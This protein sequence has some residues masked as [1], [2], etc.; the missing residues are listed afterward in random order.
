MSSGG[1]HGEMV[2]EVC[3]T[4]TFTLDG[5]FYYCDGCGER[6]KGHRETEIEYQDAPLVN[7]KRSQKKADRPKG[8][9]KGPRERPRKLR[10]DP[11]LCERALA[12]DG[13]FPAYMDTVGTRICTSTKIVAKVASVLT[14]EPFRLPKQCVHFS[15]LILFAYFRE[16]SV[17]FCEGETAADA[18]K[19]AFCPLVR[20]TKAEIHKLRK[21][22]EAQAKE[23]RTQRRRERIE[24]ST[25]WEQLT[26]TF[27]A[28]SGDDDSDE[29]NA[30]EGAAERWKTEPISLFQ[31][32]TTA[33]STKAVNMAAMLYLGID[34]LLCIVFLA[35]QMV[36]AHWV[37]LS[38]IFRWYRE[39][40][41]SVSH[42]QLCALNFS[43]CWEL[44]NGRS[45]AEFC[46]SRLSRRFFGRC[47]FTTPYYAIQSSSESFRVLS[48]L[49]QFVGI[50]KS[51][52]TAPFKH[53]LFRLVYNL[54]L[55]CA[56]E[57][58]LS[59]LLD[60]L[61]SPLFTDYG[62][63]RLGAAI[64]MIDKNELLQL[65]LSVPIGSQGPKGG[66]RSVGF[67][68]F[69]RYA[70][71]QKQHERGT[72]AENIEIL[73]DRRRTV[74]WQWLPMPSE[75]NAAALV[76]FAMKLFFGLDGEDDQQQPR[77]GTD[78]ATQCADGDSP[79]PVFSF[80]HWLLQLQLRMHC[81]QGTTVQKV[82]DKTFSA[83]QLE[84]SNI[85]IPYR[86]PT[87]GYCLGGSRLFHR[88]RRQPFAGCVPNALHNR[89][90]P[91]LFEHSFPR[92]H[93]L[94]VTPSVLLPISNEELYAPLQFQS[95]LSRLLLDIVNRNHWNEAEQTL[96]EQLDQQNTK[97]FFR[98]FYNSNLSAYL[99]THHG[100]EP[101]SPLQKLFPRSDKYSRFP[102]P[103][104]HPP[105]MSA[106]V[107]QPLRRMKWLRAIFAASEYT[108]PTP[109]R[110]L[111][112]HL[113]LCVSEWE[114]VL[115]M[116][117]LAIQGMF[118]DL[119]SGR[120]RPIT[121][122]KQRRRPRHGFCPSSASSSDEAATEN[123]Q[124]EVRQG[125][126]AAEEEHAE[127]EEAETEHQLF[128]I[129]SS[130]SSEEEDF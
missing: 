10:V 119:N 59:A 88:C 87:A 62:A 35:V 19:D 43:T 91:R 39:G 85:E 65:L 26:R 96:V 57:R 53:V 128:M 12:Q 83:C 45:N 49:T 117:F 54:N 99:P 13:D 68:T 103:K 6:S 122:E 100:N 34:L 66:N 89:V 105:R 18:Q 114:E 90:Q 109:F 64:P 5:G 48:F 25:V 17:A 23:R 80:D 97:I 42:S 106:I 30:A 58:Q 75:V 31:R 40:R 104:I 73:K 76:L 63:Q 21:E 78:D 124:K 15:R 47:L 121:K 107:A 108:M 2:C 93:H 77:D 22:R 29:D 98:N 27:T 102:H 72:N 11:H 94:P 110:L 61:P 101:I 46:A 3:G 79:S 123:Q 16:A 1:D 52:Q 44:D 71:G 37:Q 60:V 74:I 127:E 50:P 70:F 82:L 28:G 38:D 36:G 111:L 130:S 126:E 55:P 86:R 113:A 7:I 67:I 14:D 115:Y 8:E 129:S 24:Q 118:I 4:D 112:R 116:A 84:R 9:G 33:L 120:R 95:V 81:W 92:L 41:F 69:L 51:I 56:F 125:T 20:R 32:V